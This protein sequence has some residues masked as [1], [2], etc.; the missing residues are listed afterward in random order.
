MR[1]WRLA[2][3]DE[4]KER[5]RQINLPAGDPP[6]FALRQDDEFAVDNADGARTFGRAGDYVVLQRDKDEDE[7]WIAT[8]LA[9]ESTLAHSG[10]VENRDPDAFIPKVE[11]IEYFAGSEPHRTKLRVTLADGQAFEHEF[12]T[13]APRE[14]Q[15]IAAGITIG[16]HYRGAA[17]TD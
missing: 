3:A 15:L 2:D 6:R 8:S 11:K 10:P 9:I 12:H 17:A 5:G 4:I 13:H 14:H 16:E 1:V 7:V